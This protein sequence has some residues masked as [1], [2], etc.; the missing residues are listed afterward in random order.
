MLTKLWIILGKGFD[1]RTTARNIV[2]GRKK[3]V[4]PIGSTGECGESL[5]RAIVS[6]GRKKE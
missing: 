3:R 5:V 6:D 4:G 1:A 2:N